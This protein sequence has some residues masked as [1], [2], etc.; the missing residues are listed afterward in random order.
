MGKGE[1]RL[2]EVSQDPTP[3]PLCFSLLLFRHSTTIKDNSIENLVYQVLL[4]KIAHALQ[5]KKS[6][7]MFVKDTEITNL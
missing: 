2:F 6:T 3:T 7:V 1:G 4:S 5:A